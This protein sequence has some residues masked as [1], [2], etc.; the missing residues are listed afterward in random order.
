MVNDKKV[1]PTVYGVGINDSKYP[2]KDCPYHRVWSS[3]LSRCYSPRVQ[4]RYPT[5]KG[6][7]VEEGWKTLSVFKKWMEAQQWEGRYLDKDLLVKGNKVY[8]AD[9]CLFVDSVVNTFIPNNEFNSNGFPTGVTWRKKDQRFVAQ[10]SNPIRKSI[11]DL[12]S[13][14]LPSEAYDQWLYRKGQ[15][16]EELASMQTDPRVAQA[17][18]ERF[19]PSNRLLELK[20]MSLFAR[21]RNNLLHTNAK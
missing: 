21:V 10:I 17:L 6:C 11:E 9:T 18:R 7:T 8:S 16:A 20:A 12:G 19:P 4:E 15:L 3:M 1:K 14:E 13:Y 2:V 5:Y